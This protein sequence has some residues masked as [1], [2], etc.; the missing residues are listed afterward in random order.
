M[1]REKEDTKRAI[2]EPLLSPE[3]DLLEMNKHAKALADYLV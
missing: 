2:D 3:N 1:Q